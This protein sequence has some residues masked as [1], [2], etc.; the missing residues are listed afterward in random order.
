MLINIGEY[1]A[2]TRPA[3]IGIADAQGDVFDIAVLHNQAIATSSPS[4]YLF[5]DGTSHILHPD[6]SKKAAIWD[7]VSVVAKNAMLAD[8]YSTAL[9][10]AADEALA[11][12]LIAKSIV[13]KIILKNTNGHISRIG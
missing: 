13:Q 10:L 4:T 7:S 6:G 3:K 2:G 11:E 8:G 9:T 5:P 12:K 1:S